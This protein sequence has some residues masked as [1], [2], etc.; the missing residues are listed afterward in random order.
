MKCIDIVI[1]HSVSI[2]KPCSCLALS[3]GW[4]FTTGSGSI[5]SFAGVLADVLSYELWA[6]LS[7]I[8]LTA[9]YIALFCSIHLKCKVS[10]HWYIPS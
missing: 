8:L 4:C 6:L 3:A 7:F 5:D 1:S 10:L 9:L 2:S